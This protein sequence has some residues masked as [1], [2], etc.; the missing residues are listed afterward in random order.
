MDRQLLDLLAFLQN[1]VLSLIRQSKLKTKLMVVYLPTCYMIK[2]NP[3]VY[4]KL[5]TE[6]QTRKDQTYYLLLSNTIKITASM[7]TS[8]AHLAEEDTTHIF[9]QKMNYVSAKYHSRIQL[10]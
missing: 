2:K 1:L 7:S 10:K 6:V 5:N 8:T 4:F 3:D 9:Y